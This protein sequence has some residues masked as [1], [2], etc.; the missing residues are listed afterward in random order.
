VGGPGSPLPPGVRKV[1]RRNPL[2]VAALQEIRAL[3][4]RLPADERQ[5]LEAR[6]AEQLAELARKEDPQEWDWADGRVQAL[7]PQRYQG[8][9]TWDPKQRVGLLTRT[10]LVSRFS[11]PTQGLPWEPQDPEAHKAAYEAGQLSLQTYLAVLGKQKA[12]KSRRSA[13]Y[14]SS[15]ACG[16]RRVKRREEKLPAG[17][18]RATVRGTLLTYREEEGQKARVRTYRYGLQLDCDLVG[19]LDQGTILVGQAIQQAL[20]WTG[21]RSRRNTLP[22]YLWGGVASPQLLRAPAQA[23]TWGT[24]LGNLARGAGEKR[25]VRTGPPQSS[26]RPQTVKPKTPSRVP[27]AQSAQASFLPWVNQ[28]Q[29]GEEDW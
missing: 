21:E 3:L 11:P 13:M 9:Q 27:V 7:M 14:A 22:I 18:R 29:G 17:V 5:R 19:R 15:A 20:L 10:N 8:P 25:E 12:R 23:L 2:D 1:I 24:V 28:P 4:G 6:L 16:L 26:E